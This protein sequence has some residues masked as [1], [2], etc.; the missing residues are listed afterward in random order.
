MLPKISMGLALSRP[1]SLDAKILTQALVYMLDLMIHIQLLPN[2]LI[3]LLKIIM[4]TRKMPNISVI[5]TI[6]S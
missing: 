1:Y 6:K 2:F 3:R 4:A 5:W